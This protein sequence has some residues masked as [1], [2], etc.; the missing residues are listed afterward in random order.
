MRITHVLSACHDQ[1][2]LNAVQ[3]IIQNMMACEDTSQQQLH[4]LQ[5]CG[6]GGLWRFAGPYTKYNGTAESSELFVNCL[7]A[8][9]ET[10]LPVEETEGENGEM[11]QYPSMLSVSS[12]MNLSS[13][14]SSL[15]LGS[16]TEKEMIS[17]DVEGGSSTSLGRISCGGG[18]KQRSST[19]NVSSKK[20]NP[21]G[22]VGIDGPPNSSV[23]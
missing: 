12:N 19:C 2:I 11:Q 8:M 13:S 1:T 17:R 10:C 14:M 9:V 16:P 7:E 21:Y 15:T 5:S 3:T 23:K 18:G 22:A 6:F 4:Y 20:Q